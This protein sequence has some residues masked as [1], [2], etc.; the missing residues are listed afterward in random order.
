MAG[1]FLEQSPDGGHPILR[2]F[3]RRG[4]GKNIVRE[5][6]ICKT[7]IHAFEIPIFLTMAVNNDHIDV[8][9]RGRKTLVGRNVG[10]GKDLT[11]INICIDRR[12][13]EQP[14]FGKE[15]RIHAEHTADSRIRND[16]RFLLESLEKEELAVIRAGCTKESDGGRL[17]GRKRN[18]LFTRCIHD[19]LNDVFG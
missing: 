17:D 3:K 12:Q 1:N 14:L 18:A 4:T 8:I 10:Y 13:A 6:Q 16:I 19:T 7:G 11:N 5:L 2:G 15:R 9:V